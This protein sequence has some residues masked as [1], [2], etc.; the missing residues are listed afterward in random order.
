MKVQND[1]S[2]ISRILFNKRKLAI[3]R[4]ELD[5]ISINQQRQY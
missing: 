4:E 1:N 2:V 3:N 5:M